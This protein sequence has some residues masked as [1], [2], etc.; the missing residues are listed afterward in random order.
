MKAIRQLYVQVLIGIALAIVL[1]IAAP[2]IAVQMKPLG[3]AFI[4]LLRML[5]APIIFCSVVL[6]LTHVRDMGQ[7]GR[8]AVKALLYFE[9]MSTLAMLLGFVVVNIIQPG[10]GLHAGN[11]ATDAGVTRLTA[12]A[13]NFTAVGFFLSIIPNTLVDA[14][15]KGEVLQVLFI[16]VLTGAALSVGGAGGDSTILKVIAEAQNVLFRVLGFIM[17]LAPLGAFGAMAAAVGAFGAAT[18]VYL[19]KLVLL[20]WATSLFFVVVVLGA[21]TAM[22]GLSIF[23]LLRLI[24]E[25]LLLVLGTASGEVALPRLILKLEQAG[26]DEAIV[27]FVLPGGYSFNL[28]GTSIYM[29]IAVAFIAQ[30]T[31]TPFSLW[32]QAGV[33][34][35]LLLTSKGGTT[36]A[37]GAFIKLAAT[38]QTVRTLPLNG[39]GLLFGIDRMMATCTALTNVVG[40]TVAVFVV[41]KWEGAFDQAKFDAYLAAQAKG[42]DR[43]A[44]LPPQPVQG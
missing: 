43:T 3:D 32:Q 21:V 15:A 38:L 20:Y 22:A 4:A 7:L 37:G 18:L 24:R 40:N 39:L 1:G 35:I 14:F 29:A 19:A 13:S 11:I 16:S 8:L 12:A 42:R 27:G 25:E 2:G 28:D 36:V 17:R 34:A 26:C 41:A 23:K 44:V 5:L 6:G 30:A 10:A 9:V 33:L 31:D